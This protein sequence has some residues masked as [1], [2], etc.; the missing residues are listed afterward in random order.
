VSLKFSIEISKRDCHLEGAAYCDPIAGHLYLAREIATAAFNATVIASMHRLG[1]RVTH[2]HIQKKDLKD[3]LDYLRRSSRSVKLAQAKVAAVATNAKKKFELGA[4]LGIGLVLVSAAS[5]IFYAVQ[6]R[7]AASDAE[8]EGHLMKRKV[9]VRYQDLQGVPPSS[10]Q[11]AA[12]Q[13]AVPSTDPDY[14]WKSECI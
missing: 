6:K 4:G 13:E 12:A 5:A 11:A 10:Y 1:A 3:D 8:D 2:L 14:I 7:R 9:T